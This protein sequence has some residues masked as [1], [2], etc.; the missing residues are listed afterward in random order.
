MLG[1]MDDWRVLH[2]CGE[3][4]EAR[5]LATCLLAME[6]PARVR[7]AGG[8]VVPLVPDDD[9]RTGCFLV[10]VP[11]AEA[12]DLAPLVAEILAEQRAFDAMLDAGRAAGHRARRRVLLVLAV[13]VAALATAG[14]IEL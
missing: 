14:L 6:F 10:E 8:P 13:L 7:R 1:T 2:R 3:P 5:C 9:D 4:A 12:V 11:A